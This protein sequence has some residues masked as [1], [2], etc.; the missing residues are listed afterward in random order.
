MEKEKRAVTPSYVGPLAQVESWAD[1]FISGMIYCSLLEQL[2]ERQ[3][4][5]DAV[6]AST[7]KDSESY[8][9]ALEESEDLDKVWVNLWETYRYEA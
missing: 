8:G 1:D 2:V 9:V 5:V 7:A 3:A 6:L 4:A